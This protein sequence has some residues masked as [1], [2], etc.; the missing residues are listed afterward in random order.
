MLNQFESL[1]EASVA[2]VLG[3]MAR[4]HAADQDQHDTQ[5]SL[6]A[7]LGGSALPEQP[8]DGSKSWN[9]DLVLD[10]LKRAGPQLQ[11]I[12]VMENL[13]FEG[14]NVPDANG[15]L[16]LMTAWKRL[17]SEAF[18]LQASPPQKPARLGPWRFGSNLLA[19]YVVQLSPGLLQQSVP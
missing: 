6:A 19:A 14:F 3:M 8:W 17:S 4:T 13:D 7:A 15:F 9:M 18:P 16:V 11:P 12:G 10:M 1:D 2:R 5:A